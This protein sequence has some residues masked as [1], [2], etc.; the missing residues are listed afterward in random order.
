M[1]LF[2]YVINHNIQKENNLQEQKFTSP[3][4]GDNSEDI[5]DILNP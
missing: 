1:Y 3:V 5:N 4:E 2:I